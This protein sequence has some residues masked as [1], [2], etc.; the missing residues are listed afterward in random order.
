MNAA[1]ATEFCRSRPGLAIGWPIVSKVPRFAQRV[2]LSEARIYENL[3]LAS[4]LIPF[5]DSE[6]GECA[7][8]S[9]TELGHIVAQKLAKNS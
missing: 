3:G 7:N 5:I 6:L 1:Q 4:E 9:V 2:R 8:F